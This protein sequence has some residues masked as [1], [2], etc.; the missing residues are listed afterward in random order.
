LA[1]VR[2]ACA[3]QDHDVRAFAIAALG[4]ARPIETVK[5]DLL[6]ALEDREPAVVRE[7]A[8]I[9]LRESVDCSRELGPR[10]RDQ[11]QVHALICRQD[12][13]AVQRLGSAAFPALFRAAE[14]DNDVVR[15]EA[16]A[17]LRQALAHRAPH[18][19]PDSRAARAD[20]R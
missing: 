7:A 5:R 19:F 13:R 4:G 8:D 11:I 14:S 10:Y 1:L 2:R 17:F 16:R 12:W 9:L 15:R 6:A 18:L 20:P 3:S